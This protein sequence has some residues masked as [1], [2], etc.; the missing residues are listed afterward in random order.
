MSIQHRPLNGTDHIPAEVIEQILDNTKHNTRT[1]HACCF[2]CVGWHSYLIDS[3]YEVEPIRLHSKPQ[4]YKLARAS[5]TYPAVRDRLALARSVILETVDW[6]EGGFA[7]VFPLVLG[8]RLHKVHDLTLRNCLGQPLRPNFF[9]KL[10]QL[11][12]VKHLVLSGSPPQKFADFQRIVCAFP[13]LEELDIAG[14]WNASRNASQLTPQHVL[15]LPCMSKL[16]CVRASDTLPE[17]CRDLVAWLS[18]RGVCSTISS[19]NISLY[20][21]VLQGVSPFDALLTQT[22]STLE[23]LRIFIVVKGTHS[24]LHAHSR[25]HIAC[26]SIG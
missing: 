24:L 25:C 2:V 4:I 19:L 18:S 10:R 17:F 21:K 20:K 7:H 12:D 14:L 16:T 8:P 3:L 15:N 11:T 26:R 13:Q 23:R 6:R 5:R 1:L 22:A 9:L